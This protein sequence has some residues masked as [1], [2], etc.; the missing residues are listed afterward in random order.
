MFK[1]SRANIL[2]CW[3]TIRTFLAWKVIMKCVSNIWNFENPFNCIQYFLC[4]IWWAKG[5]F[6]SQWLS[7]HNSSVNKRHSYYLNAYMCIYFEFQWN[8]IHMFCF[9]NVNACRN[10]LLIRCQINELP[11]YAKS[12]AQSTT[13]SLT[14]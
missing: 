9:L 5:P 4:G 8:Y 2:K 13:S 3:A 11:I 7:Y 10:S 14:Y 12:M 1:T 6:M